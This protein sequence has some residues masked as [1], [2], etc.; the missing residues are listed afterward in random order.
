LYRGTELAS[1]ILP[2]RTTEGSSW[3]EGAGIPL[4]GTT[5]EFVECAPRAADRCRS[6]SA[7]GDKSRTR[8]CAASARGARRRTRSPSPGAD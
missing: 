4:E 3:W 7:A 8:A 2:D 6:C 5:E 1:Y